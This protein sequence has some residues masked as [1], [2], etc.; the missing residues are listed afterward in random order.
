MSDFQKFIEIFISEDYFIIFLALLFI[1][2]IILV[3]AL[4]K[5]KKD[6]NE[7]NYINNYKNIN[8]D[9]IDS[10]KEIKDLKEEDN[11]SDIESIINNIVLAPQIKTY[12]NLIDEYECS[13]EENAVISTEELERKTKERI[14]ALGLNENETIIQQYEEEQEQKAIISYEQLLKNASNINVTYIEEKR[15]EDAPK[16]DKIEILERNIEPA[17]SYIAEEDFLNILKEFRVL[18]E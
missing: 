6:Y 1:I 8:N 16:V 5:T 18:L 17:Q 3:I 14:E 2:L 10:V 13:E 12:E 9:I 15:D 4:I 11:K 7:L